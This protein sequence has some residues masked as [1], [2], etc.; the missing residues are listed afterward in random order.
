MITTWT[1]SLLVCSRFCCFFFYFYW[2][3]LPPSLTA[4]PRLAAPW[5][6]W[7]PHHVPCA[8]L[9]FDATLRKTKNKRRSVRACQGPARLKRPGLSSFQP[10]GKQSA[11][12]YK[13]QKV[14]RCVPGPLALCMHWSYLL[15]RALSRRPLDTSSITGY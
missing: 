1:G 8:E 3:A 10:R 6:S 5:S 12:T 9:A 11:P 13:A 15:V 7:G 4:T 2:L 14:I